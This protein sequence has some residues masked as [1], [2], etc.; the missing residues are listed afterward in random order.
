MLQWRLET[1]LAE[2]LLLDQLDQKHQ[3]DLVHQ[4]S[5]VQSKEQEEVS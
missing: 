1:D 3:K 5:P 2:D 4:E